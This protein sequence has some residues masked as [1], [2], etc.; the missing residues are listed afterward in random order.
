MGVGMSILDRLLPNVAQTFY[1]E[2]LN[3]RLGTNNLTTE[4]IVEVL[5]K[6][7]MTLEDLISVP[8]KD[9]WRY[10]DNKVA[11]VCS[12]F[13]MGL[14]RAAG[15]FPNLDFEVTEFTPKDSYQV[16]IFDSNWKRPA[17]C[18]VDDLPYC[19]LNGIYKLELPNWNSIDL[20]D[21]MN[22]KCGALPPKYEREPPFC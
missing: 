22:E 5:L 1:G 7:N 11:L 18:L 10:D 12:S 16:K 17:P 20:Y 4:E 6:K 21:H 2:A 9:S 19:Q 13:A 3:K 15:L 8:E 14:Y